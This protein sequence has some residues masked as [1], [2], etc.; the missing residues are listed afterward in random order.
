MVCSFYLSLGFEI[1]MRLAVGTCAEFAW[2]N[3]VDVNLACR[4]SLSANESRTVDRKYLFSYFHIQNLRY[5]QRDIIP[6]TFIHLPSDSLLCGVC[7]G[8]K[9]QTK[10]QIDVEFLNLTLVVFFLSSRFVVRS[11][12]IRYFYPARNIC[13][14]RAKRAHI[15]RRDM[16]LHNS[17]QK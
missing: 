13:S 3:N 8:L 16:A 5:R 2:K 1:R 7:E 4:F 9:W 10:L 6:S 17:W 11:K 15:A 12:A 14:V